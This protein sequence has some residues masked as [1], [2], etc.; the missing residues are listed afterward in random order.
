MEIW[1]ENIEK[2]KEKG[3]GKEKETEPEKEKEEVKEK[4]K[5]K[6]TIGEKQPSIIDIGNSPRKKRKSTK[7]TYQAVLNED[8]FTTI[9]D[10]VCDSMMKP[11]TTFTST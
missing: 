6:A 9:A 1:V 4:D 8:D 11:I 7:P 3:K 2:E 5:G 10:R